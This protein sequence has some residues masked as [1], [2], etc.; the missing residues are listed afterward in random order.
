MCDRCEV[1]GHRDSPF[2]FPMLPFIW[3]RLLLAISIATDGLS[4][5]CNLRSRE[6]ISCFF[7]YG[8][9]VS[10]QEV[11]RNA[12]EELANNLQYDSCVDEHLQDQVDCV[13]L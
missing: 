8:Q 12:V 3:F 7:F 4:E 6:V 11:A 2:P 9:G 10:P 5:T 1:R 13:D